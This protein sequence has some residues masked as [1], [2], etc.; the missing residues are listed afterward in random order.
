MLAH[1]EA[2]NPSNP[3]V[4]FV[5]GVC[6]VGAQWAELMQHLADRY[7]LIAF[8]SLGHGLSERYTQEDLASP[9]D[10]AMAAL[11]E[12]LEYQEKLHGKRAAVIAHSMGAAISSK[13]AV[14]RPELF[15]GLILEDPAWLNDQQRAGYLNRSAEQVELSNMWRNDPVENLRNNT[16]ERPHWSSTSH[17]AWAYGKTLVDPNLI[18]TGVVSFPDAWEDVAAAITV[19]TVVI[20]SNTDR[21]LVGEAG[22]A[23]IAQLANPVLSVEMIPDAGHGVRLDAPESFYAIVDRQLQY[24]FAAQSGR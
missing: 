21:V 11:A 23:A 10:A 22:A 19:P 9:A 6:D 12:A 13:L 5:H 20:T 8:D 2:G 14:H 7:F 18:A 1:Y 3:M 4:A 16:L 15:T 24:L 17:T